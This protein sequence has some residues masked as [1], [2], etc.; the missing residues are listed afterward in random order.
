VAKL[1]SDVNF[2]FTE[3][4]PTLRRGVYV[5]FHD[6][7]PAAWLNEGRVWTEAYVLRAFLTFNTD[8][9]IVLFNTFLEHFHRNQFEQY[10][11]LCLENEGG[12]IWLR[13]IR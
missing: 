6:I 4:L 11:P 3:I 8:Y 1:G 5:H 9:E 10:M 7:F 2:I 12:S 13:R